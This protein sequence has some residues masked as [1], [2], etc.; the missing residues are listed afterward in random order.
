MHSNPISAHALICSNSLFPCDIPTLF[1]QLSSTYNREFCVTE[2]TYNREFCI[3]KELT[4][5]FRKQILK[6]LINTLNYFATS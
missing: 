3:L 5:T 1:L 2:S 4:Y 6:Q